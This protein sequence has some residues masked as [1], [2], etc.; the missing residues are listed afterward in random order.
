MSPE[1]IRTSGEMETTMSESAQTDPRIDNQGVIHDSW[2]NISNYTSGV[3]NCHL[4]TIASLT[5]KVDDWK[6]QTSLEAKK[7]L[8]LMN[9]NYELA[10]ASDDKSLI[11]KQ[12]IREANRLRSENASLTEKVERLRLQVI[13]YAAMKSYLRDG[14]DG[15]GKSMWHELAEEERQRFRD[16]VYEDAFDLPVTHE[17]EYEALKRENERLKTYASTLLELAL[18]DVELPLLTAEEQG[19]E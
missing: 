14:P 18:D 16:F 9:E 3:C 19:D 17:S 8:A 5:E 13:E 2:Y 15:S 12:H 4:S 10:Q 1:S 11:I 7:A 6:E